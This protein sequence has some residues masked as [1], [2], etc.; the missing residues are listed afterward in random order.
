MQPNDFRVFVSELERPLGDE[1]SAQEEQLFELVE[2]CDRSG[3]ERF[4]ADNQVNVNA[5]NYQGITPL[6]LAIKNNCEPLVELFLRQTGKC[7]HLSPQQCYIDRK[8]VV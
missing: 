6:H 3:V 8:S 5:K 1:L 4:L 2:T 7:L